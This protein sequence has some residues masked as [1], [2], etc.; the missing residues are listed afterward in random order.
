MAA[1]EQFFVADIQQTA[2]CNALHAVEARMCR[3]LLRMMDLSQAKV[4]LTQDQLAAMIGV[5]RTSVSQGACRLQSS[6]IITY[7]RGAISITD[8]KGLKNSAC[9]CYETVRQNY[10]RIFGISPPKC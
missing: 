6:G 10:T 2:V 5:G 3:W 1:H 9:E 4:Q 8:V 7:G